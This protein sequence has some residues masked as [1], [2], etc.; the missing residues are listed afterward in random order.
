MP[1]DDPRSFK[2]TF[3]V[4]ID[5]FLDEGHRLLRWVATL[6]AVPVFVSAMAAEHWPT[7]WR[8]SSTLAHAS[9]WS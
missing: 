2:V 8:R 1:V 6:L 5:D 4:V 7:P 3:L 9:G